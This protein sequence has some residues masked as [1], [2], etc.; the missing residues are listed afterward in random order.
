MFQF[1]FLASL[2]LNV[3]Q[4]DLTPQNL[5]DTTVCIKFENENS[6]TQ[7][8]SEK[9]YITHTK[10]TNNESSKISVKGIECPI[11][12]SKNKSFSIYFRTRND[13]KNIQ[14]C[15]FKMEVTKNKRLA[16]SNGLT[17]KKIEKVAASITQIDPIKKVYS[18][19]LTSPLSTG[20]YGFAFVN[21]N[22][23]GHFYYDPFISKS[24][25]C[26]EITE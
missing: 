6:Y 21:V 9:G 1:L 12:I 22:T 15:M 11:K 17:N 26:I 5:P 18:M 23:K 19:T 2:T 16:T 10:S 3:P 13:I 8:K 20:V 25:Y 14:F 7:L 24:V 4:D